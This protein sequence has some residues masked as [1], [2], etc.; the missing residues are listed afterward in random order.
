MLPAVG[1]AEQRNWVRFVKT[2]RPAL[3]VSAL[4]A[5]EV[6]RPVRQPFSS[7]NSN[8]GHLNAGLQGD[9]QR[10]QG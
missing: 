7:M 1:L 9:L 4:A 2:S 5:F 3:T 10:L 6:V 8:L